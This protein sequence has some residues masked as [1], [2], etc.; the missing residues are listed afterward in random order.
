MSLIKIDAVKIV[1]KQAANI[2]AYRDRLL[3]ASDWT[4]VADAP[5]DQTV[6]AAYRQALRDIPQQEGFPHNVAWP[7]KP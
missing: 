4:Q 2:R 5:V 7:V 6:W 1:A 3:A